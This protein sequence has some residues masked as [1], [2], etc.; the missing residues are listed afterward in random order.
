MKLLMISPVPTDPPTAGNRARVSNLITIL[1][2]LGHD[3]SLAYVPYETA[4]YNAMQTR[5]GHRLH[6]LHAECPPFSSIAGR[7]KRKIQRVLRL[8]SAY[9]WRV[10]EWFDDRLLSQVKNLQNTEHFDT[11][12]IEYVFLSKLRSA[13][14][15]SVRII[16]DTHDIMGDR[17]KIYLNSGLK[18][19]WFATTQEEESRA[20]N[21]ADAVIAIQEHE[22]QYLRRQVSVEVFCV[23]HISP[24]DIVPLADQGGSR[25]LF[26]GSAN[27]INIHGLESFVRSAL[28]DIRAKVPGCELAIAGRAGQERA[29]PNGVLVLGEVQALAPIYAEAT[30]VINPVTFGT[31]FPVKTIEA[32]SYGKPLVT[33]TAGA[34]GL[35]P[36]FVGAI[37]VAENAADFARQVVD[38]LQNEAARCCLSTNAYLAFHAW[39]VRQ[40]ASLQDAICGK[41][42]SDAGRSPEVA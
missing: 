37:S 20:L 38:L 18:P 1:Q 36:E 42:R 5:L 22:A 19:A 21:R 26:V 8:K 4:D 30:V 31:G 17:H 7:A 9:L 24:I 39:R 12:L 33:T 40:V 14:S 10:D 11:V 41:R 16:V 35:G 23:G 28:P 27:P 32:L 3:V 29:W 13:F 15:D 2:H 6:I 34:R 25:L